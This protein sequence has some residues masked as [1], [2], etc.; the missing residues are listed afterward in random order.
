MRSLS[1]A[2]PYNVTVSVA[3]PLSALHY[4]FIAAAAMAAGFVNAIAGGGTL[5][6]FPVMT[7]MGIPPVAANVTNTVAL[8]PGF[9]GAAL[10]QRRDLIG[11]GRRMLVTIPA[12]VIGGLAGGILLLNTE[13][14]LFRSLIPYLILAAAA[15][16]A[17]QDGLR[18]WLVRRGGHP[19]TG[20][21]S[22]V[23]AAVF[24]GIAAIY[25][26]YFGAGLGV[27]MLAV[28]GLVLD[29]TLT[30]LNA[31]KIIMAF[32]INVAAAVFFLFSG[33]VLW[34]AALVMAVGAIIG[35]GIGGQFASRIAPRTLRN[36]VVTLAVVASA[37]YLVK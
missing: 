30:R 7:A 32:V 20:H 8:C 29:D 10:G 6:T 33:Q 37:I 4:A 1:S 24:L 17:A 18:N 3:H 21:S 9:V 36:V 14:Q 11:Q 2:L 31:L 28:M 16:L 27:I 19:G 25:G 26:G 12:G 13:E 23:R 34:T 35:G 15:L 22:N 5:I